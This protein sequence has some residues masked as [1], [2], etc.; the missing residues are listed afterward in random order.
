MIAMALVNDPQLLIADEPTTALDVTVQAQILELLAR[1]QAE[2][3]M[4]IVIITHDLGIVAELADEVAVMYAGRIV[5]QA[6]TRDAVRGARA[7]VHVGPAG[8]DPAPGPPARGG[9]RRDRRPPA[10]PHQPADRLPLPPALSARARRAPHASSPSSPPSK[11]IRGT[12]PPACSTAARG[13]R[14][15]ARAPCGRGARRGPAGGGPEAGRGRRRRSR[16]DEPR[17]DRGARPRQALRAHAGHRAA[18]LRRGARGRRGVVRRARGRDARHR[19]RERLRQVDHRAPAAA[20]A[21]PDVGHDRA[22]R[23]RHHDALAQGAAAAAPRDADDLPGPVL[24]AEPAPHGRL[25]HLRAVR[26]PRHRARRAASA[27]AACRS[28]WRASG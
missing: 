10:E 25:D 6:P 8:V 19:R 1:L 15:G 16:R 22:R 3:G 13:A 28:S 27:S 24:V 18:Q 2:R 4:A 5:E 12:S 9:A 21:R 7:P 23:P 20:A 11:A 17:A 26:D 14:C